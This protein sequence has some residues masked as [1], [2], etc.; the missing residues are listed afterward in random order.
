MISMPKTQARALNFGDG[1]TLSIL[2]GE[3][4]NGFIGNAAPMKNDNL[5]SLDRAVD[6]GSD[7][8]YA[9]LLIDG[10]YDFMYDQAETSAW[11]PYI[12][13]GLGVAT[14]AAQTSSNISDGATYPLFRMGGGVAYRLGDQWNLSLDYTKNIVGQALSGDRIFTGR[15][16]QPVDLQS[17]NMGLKLQF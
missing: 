14:S 11:R 6:L 17:L 1:A 2:G 10:R 5:F 12:A 16:Q 13:G 8:R 7:Q 4:A 15:G 3:Y 9:A